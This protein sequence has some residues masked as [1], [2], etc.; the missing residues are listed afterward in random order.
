MKFTRAGFTLIEL[1]I[2]MVIMVILLGLGVVSLGNI[3]A[4]ARDKERSEDIAI[5]AR[6]LENRY[7]LG[8]P[9][10]T[11]APAGDVEK[12]S[13]PGVNETLHIDGW[14]RDG[15]TPEQ[16]DGNYRSEAF[17][18]TDDN[19]FRNPENAWAWYI[20]CVWACQPA[21]D[22]SQLQTA[23][24]A[25]DGDKYVY[26]PY[27]SNGNICCCGGCVGYNLYW[28]SETDSTVVDGVAGLQIVRSKHR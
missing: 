1:M 17:P 3:Q 6:G 21:G 14:E 16:H 4:Q 12:G 11:G 7:N 9:I 23:F 15:Y 26:E 20:V 24:A 19:S 22:A 5:I 2:V 8:N 18:G 13:Y 10:V 25:D 28:K 27:D